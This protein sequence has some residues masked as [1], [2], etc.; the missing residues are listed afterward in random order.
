MSQS[1]AFGTNGIQ[2]VGY[3]KVSYPDGPDRALLWSGSA[4]SAVD[5]TPSGFYR[6]RALGVS[7]GQQVG[8]GHLNGYGPMH[9]LL[10]SGSAA[11]A[12]DLNPSGFDESEAYGTNG[13]EQVG[14]GYPAW[15]QFGHALI[16]SGTADSVVDLNQ[17]LP[18]SWSSSTYA[19]AKSI[20]AQGNIVGYAS[21]MGVSHAILWVPVPE[22]AAIVTLG[23]G[24]LTLGFVLRRKRK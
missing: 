22:P 5:L 3:G 9:A 24:A 11:S 1:Y 15:S 7:G 12:V 23:M 17:F 21:D 2:Q 16:W 4:A 10:W 6:S 13:T 14:F 19:V 20:D 8:S 18:S